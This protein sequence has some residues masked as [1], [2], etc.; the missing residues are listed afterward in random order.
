[1]KSAGKEMKLPSLQGNFLT[2]GGGI[3]AVRFQNVPASKN[4]LLLA[5]TAG[6]PQG[7]AAQRFKARRRRGD[8]DGADIRRLTFTLGR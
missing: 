3:G 5:F 2:A 8:T 6:V 1:M 7:G 4:C